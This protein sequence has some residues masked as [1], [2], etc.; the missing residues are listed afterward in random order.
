MTNII[1]ARIQKTLNDHFME[2]IHHVLNEFGTPHSDTEIADVLKNFGESTKTVKTEPS[3]KTVKTSEPSTKTTASVVKKK[4]PPAKDSSAPVKSVTPVDTKT[5]QSEEKNCCNYRSARGKNPNQICGKNA[6]V[7]IDGEWYCGTKKDDETYT[8]HAKSAFIAFQKREQQEK[9]TKSVTKSPDTKTV[10]VEKTTSAVKKAAE[11]VKKV[12]PTEKAKI[13]KDKKTNRYV[14]EETGIVF[15]KATKKATGWQDER[16]KLHDLDAKHMKICDKHNWE[17]DKP[18]PAKSVATKKK[19]EPEP[20][21]DVDIEEEDE[22]EV[23]DE[24]EEEVVDDDEEVVDEDEEVVDEDDEEVVDE[25][26]EEVVDDDEEEVVDDDE[27]EIVDEDDEEIVDDDEVVDEE[28]EE[29]EEEFDED[30][31]ELEDD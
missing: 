30:E 20:V 18:V 14:H 10:K 8:G 23:V 6:K 7:C 21:E 16:G 11:L 5:K 29:E 2:L 12:V 19:S 17:F 22:E 31:I 26:D 1:D 9:N 24:D 27:E 3:T 15:D 25:D 28:E 13:V 4:T